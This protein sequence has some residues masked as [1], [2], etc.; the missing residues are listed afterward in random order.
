MQICVKTELT[1][2]TNDYTHINLLPKHMAWFAV[3]SSNKVI[4]TII[5]WDSFFAPNPSIVTAGLQTII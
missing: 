3:S 1:D 5:F 2:T 4:F